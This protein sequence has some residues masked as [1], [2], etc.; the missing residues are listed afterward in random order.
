M[1]RSVSD[2]LAVW[3]YE[4][5][6]TLKVLGA[7]TDASL[8]QRF[9]PDV[10]TLG[11][12][13]WHITQSIP[14]MGARTGL[15]LAGPG[16]DDPIPGSAADIAARYR[17]AADSLTREVKSRWNDAELE[18][19]DEMYGE[20]WP[21]G[22]TLFVISGHQAH[23]RAQMMVLMRLAGLPVPGVY[24]PTKEEWGQFGMPAQE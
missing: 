3:D 5:E 18:L 4:A 16:E 1:F 2:F 8:V 12:L 11:R 9:H 13:A 24:G 20:R 6:A 19:E 10:R 17:E 15:A 14:E 22:R 21:R 7:L 23:H